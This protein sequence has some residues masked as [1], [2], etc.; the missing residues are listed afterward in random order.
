MPSVTTVAAT[1]ETAALIVPSGFVTVVSTVAA[2]TVTQSVVWTVATGVITLHHVSA[3]RSSSSVP[4]GVSTVV[5]PASTV[6]TNVATVVA[7]TTASA[8]AVGSVMVGAKRGL[9]R[10][11]Q[12]GWKVSGVGD[13]KLMV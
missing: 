1:T 9:L 5:V 11:L 7:T 13:A 4:Q 12:D 6:T 8:S 3:A 2:V 10:R